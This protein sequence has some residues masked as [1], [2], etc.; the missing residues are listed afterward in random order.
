MSLAFQNYKRLASGGADRSI[1][2]IKF[3]GADGVPAAIER[4]LV[5]KLRCKGMQTEGLRTETERM[6]LA[7]LIQE[8]G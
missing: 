2:L 4:R 7:R 6:K 3:D 8:C 5:L 1:A